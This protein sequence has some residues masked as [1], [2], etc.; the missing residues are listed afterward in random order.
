MVSPGGVV[1]TSSADQIF[2]V[3]LPDT[4][5]VELKP[6]VNEMSAGSDDVPSGQ[7]VYR[8]ETHLPYSL[9]PTLVVEMEL[10]SAS[11]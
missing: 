1:V 7:K 3:L 5:R 10:P 2:W 6:A 8:P 9:C 11:L 4:S